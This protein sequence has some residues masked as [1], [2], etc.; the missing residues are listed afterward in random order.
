M[1]DIKTYDKADVYFVYPE[2]WVLDESDIE[3]ADGSVQLS[4]DNG[5]F[6]ILKKHPF[7]TD[8]TEIA[9]EA[10]RTMRA[11]YQDMEVDRIDRVEFE[12][13]IVGFEMTF[14]YLDLMN[15]ACIQ[16]FEESGIVYAVF[17]QTGNQLIIHSGEMVPVEKVLEAMTISL[18]RGKKITE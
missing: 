12:K 6:W 13:N 16:C 10:L 5:A 8:P 4:N 1:A 17:W 2:N 11:E 15:L 14:F 3:T 7:G 18:L 9:A